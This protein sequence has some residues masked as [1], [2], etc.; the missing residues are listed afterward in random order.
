MLINITN[1]PFIIDKLNPGKI[2]NYIHVANQ[3]DCSPR[4]TRDYPAC[5]GWSPISLYECMDR[6]DRNEIPGNKC[7][8]KLCQYVNYYPDAKWCH[9][10]EGNCSQRAHNNAIL[11]QKLVKG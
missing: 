4:Y 1:F 6:C 3:T 9:F 7:G 5:D 2:G 8:K 10:S 11:Y